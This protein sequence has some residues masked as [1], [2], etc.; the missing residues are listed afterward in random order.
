MPLLDRFQRRI[1]V[2]E[3]QL[4]QKSERTQVDAEDQGACTRYRARCRQQ[5]PIASQH[6][7]YP[8][9]A[10]TQFCPSHHLGS[11]KIGRALAVHHDRVAVFFQPFLQLRQYLGQFRAVG[12]GNDGDESSAGWISV[13]ASGMESTIVQECRSQRSMAEAATLSS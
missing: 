1:Q 9:S 12:L 7:R 5:R 13:V 10:R 2:A 8:G 6:Q 3:W 4:R 11:L